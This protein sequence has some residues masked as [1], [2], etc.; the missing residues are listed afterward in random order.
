MKWDV[1]V[2]VQ[3]FELLSLRT[4][5]I[6]RNSSK[7][8]ARE[9]DPESCDVAQRG[10][11]SVRGRYRGG[12]PL[13]ILITRILFGISLITISIA[14]IA[15]DSPLPIFAVA[16]PQDHKPRPDDADVKKEGRRASGINK[17]RF[18]KGGSSL[19][20]SNHEKFKRILVSF[21]KP[22]LSSDELQ[23]IRTR[24]L[25]IRGLKVQP[26]TL[27]IVVFCETFEDQEKA[28]EEFYKH[29]SVKVAMKD[30]LVRSTGAKSLRG[31][32]LEAKK[33]RLL[34]GQ[35]IPSDPR[36]DRQW[37]LHQV[38]GNDADIDAP[39]AWGTYQSEAF[40]VGASPIVVAV[41]DTGVDHKHPDLAGRMWRN[42][43]EI[44]DNGIDDD[45]NGYVDD[46][47]GVDLFNQDGDP[48]DDESH[49]THCAGII[50][51]VENNNEGIAG[52]ASYTSNVQ[53]MAVKFMD[54]EGYGTLTDGIQGIEYAMENGARISSNSWGAESAGFLVW[55]AFTSVLL[56]ARMEGHLFIGASG[57]SGWNLDASSNIPCSLGADNL[58][59]VAS[60]GQFG[61]MSSFSNYGRTQVDLA[62]P[63]SSILST[64]PDGNYLY[65]S[66][67]SMSAPFVAGVAAV[68]WSFRPELSYDNVKRLIMQTVDKSDAF[69]ELSS[70]GR[71]NL[72]SALRQAQLEYP[73]ASPPVSQ[74]GSLAF[75]DT[76]QRVGLVSG[77]V[78][79]TFKSKAFEPA[80]S[81]ALDATK[82]HLYFA[83]ADGTLF[84]P[85]LNNTEPIA[86]AAGTVPTASDAAWT[87]FLPS[88]IVPKEATQI[89]GLSANATGEN[90]QAKATL[91]L[92]DTGRPQHLPKN[93][94]ISADLHTGSGSISS[95]A[96]WDV[97]L[98][99]ADVS[100]YRLFKYDS[101]TNQRVDA[102][103]PVAVVPSRGLFQP[104]CQGSA[105]ASIKVE[106]VFAVD[107]TKQTGYRVKLRPPSGAYEV[108]ERATI[109]VAGPSEIQFTFFDVEYGY[110]TL[111]IPS[112]ETTLT[113]TFT[114]ALI[115]L[116]PGTHSIKWESDETMTKEGWEFVISSDMSYKVPIEIA[117]LQSSVDTLLLI[118]SYNGNEAEDGVRAALVDNAS[119]GST[120]GAPPLSRPT[121]AKM[122][123]VNAAPG[124]MSGKLTIEC[125]APL[126]VEEKETTEES[127]T[128]S[129]TVDGSDVTRFKATLVRMTAP[130]EG[131]T[132]PP[133]E[134]H[135][136]DLGESTKASA[137]IELTDVEAGPDMRIKIVN[138]NEHAFA[139]EG[140][141]MRTLD[142]QGQPILNGKYGGD[143]DS[144][145]GQVAGD[146]SITPPAYGVGL[147]G[148]RAYW[149][150]PTST[151]EDESAATFYQAMQ[152]PIVCPPRPSNRDW[153]AD[154]TNAFAS[155]HCE[156]AFAP[157][158]KGRSCHLVQIL[159]AGDEFTISRS[160]SSNGETEYTAN[161][162]A[163]IY[164]P[165]GGELEV[166]TMDVELIFDALRAKWRPMLGGT[167]Y[168]DLAYYDPGDTLEVDGGTSESYLHWKTDMNEQRSGWVLRYRPKYPVLAIPPD[169]VMP[170]G[171]TGMKIVPVYH[172]YPMIESAAS[173][174]DEKKYAVPSELTA[175]AFEGAADTEYFVPVS[176][177]VRSEAVCLPSKMRCPIPAAW[178]DHNYVTPKTSVDSVSE[179]AMQ[180][181][182]T[183]TNG[184][185]ALFEFTKGKCGSTRIFDNARGLVVD[186]ITLV[187]EAVSDEKPT[188]SAG[189]NVA[190]T[191]D[192]SGVLDFL[193]A[194][195]QEAPVLPPEITCRC[196]SKLTATATL[197]Q[198]IG[199]EAATAPPP[200]QT[201]SVDLVGEGEM[202]TSMRVYQDEVFAQPLAFG[203]WLPQATVEFFIEV[204]TEFTG[205]HITIKSCR[206][207]RNREALMKDDDEED[208]NNSE[209]RVESDV[210]I[211]VPLMWNYC[212]V[213]LFNV[214]KH[215]APDGVTHLDRLSF[216]KFRFTGQNEIYL[217]CE[218][219]ACESR[220]CGTCFG[221]GSGEGDE[222][223]GQKFLRML[224]GRNSRV[225]QNSLKNMNKKFVGR[226][227]QSAA[228]SRTTKTSPLVVRIDENDPSA[229]TS[230]GPLG[231]TSVVATEPWLVNGNAA[232]NPDAPREP[233]IETTWSAPPM[234][235]E[236]VEK[237]ERIQSRMT[238]TG[239]EPQWAQDNVRSLED[240]LKRTLELRDGESVRIKSVGKVVKNSDDSSSTSPARRQ[241]QQ[242][243]T[244][245]PTAST[246]WVTYDDFGK[247]LS[248]LVANS[249]E[250]QKQGPENYRPNWFQNLVA[251]EQQ[252][253][254]QQGGAANGVV[255]A[256][257]AAG[258]APLAA[259]TPAPV[260][261]DIVGPQLPS[262]GQTPGDTAASVS[263]PQPASGS[264]GPASSEGDAAGV[265][266]AQAVPPAESSAAAV[267]GP[268]VAPGAPVEAPAAA[269]GVSKVKETRETIV[270]NTFEDLQKYQAGSVAPATA[271]EAARPTWFQNLVAQEK[272][273]RRE[274]G[275]NGSGVVVQAPAPI[276]SP[277]VEPTTP[278]RVPEA[279]PIPGHDE[280]RR[281]LA[282]HT[283]SHSNKRR[284]GVLRPSAATRL[285][286][287][288]LLVTNV[289]TFMD[290]VRNSRS[291]A[292]LKAQ[293]DVTSHRRQVS[294]KLAA[295]LESV[296][297]DFEVLLLKSA[298]TG[299]GTSS[300]ESAPSTSVENSASSSNQRTMLLETKMSLL[301]SGGPT[302]TNTFV[303][304]LDE[305]L[306]SRGETPVRLETERIQFREPAR[307][308][309]DIS[310][311]LTP[312]EQQG[313]SS[314]S[315]SSGDG[316]A[317]ATGTS[318]AS[319]ASDAQEEK[320]STGLLGFDAATATMLLVV[321]AGAFL[322]LL[323]VFAVCF[324][325]KW[326][327]GSSTDA[328]LL[329]PD[330]TPKVVRE[331]AKTSK[332]VVEEDIENKWNE[333]E[334]NHV[335]AKMTAVASNKGQ[336]EDGD[337][338][339][340]D[341]IGIALQIK[342]STN[343]KKGKK[344]KR[345][346]SA[347]H[348]TAEPPL[349]ITN[350]DDTALVAVSPRPS[351]VSLGERSAAS[352]SSPSSKSKNKKKRDAGSNKAASLNRIYEED[353]EIADVESVNQTSS[354]KARSQSASA[355][356]PKTKLTLTT[357]QGGSI[358]IESDDVEE[359]LKSRE[360]RK[361]L[362]KQM[363]SGAETDDSSSSPLSPSLRQASGSTSLSVFNASAL[364]MHRP[365]SAASTSNILLSTTTS[366]FGS[367]NSSP[368]ISRD[369][370]VAS[371]GS[372]PSRRRATPTHDASSLVWADRRQPLGKLSD[373]SAAVSNPRQAVVAREG[374]ASLNGWGPV[375]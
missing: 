28:I 120:G 258:D 88:S 19:R 141:I 246:N 94:K 373:Y 241:L 374:A 123:D 334:L 274:Q 175:P 31:T 83:R 49:G 364:G 126:L 108:D 239:L 285:L 125:C 33:E 367:R 322:I 70:G 43:G 229:I 197:E 38:A 326:L 276:I 215:A 216:R 47:H 178:A 54:F 263:Q 329:S 7:M 107:A 301:A 223:N 327:R 142:I 113:G 188:E 261:N 186:S 13:S 293:N 136:R 366:S 42:P 183:G 260:A 323:G 249:E 218:V 3:L 67:T 331:F 51:A 137:A 273:M 182:P 283:T 63:G 117:S 294:R 309:P 345:S 165:Y 243:A 262:G 307:I 200:V 348:S 302:L 23:D 338:Q 330:A 298:S 275:G 371:P 346:L 244:S 22:G 286:R 135:V 199:V 189:Q 265:P 180:R 97:G 209:D 226:G 143:L 168:T 312:A 347:K 266:G 133:L 272:T 156:S 333:R 110:D 232:G 105:C 1:V 297:I 284:G 90:Q 370:V 138:G 372:S 118:A 305:E 167:L 60:S 336:D 32:E 357:P 214:K 102:A 92:V 195:P 172:N 354:S 192:Y 77:E 290:H 191:H 149:S 159:Q 375:T 34:Q 147:T 267:G 242:A 130:A 44:P 114:P 190:E 279:V 75:A 314:S 173:S 277:S 295:A 339:L 299:S 337:P 313:S 196:E 264:A 291:A 27:T 46:V 68:L 69:A 321:T 213:P 240:T 193:D 198:P 99:E 157:K 319:P 115:S 96:T 161:E 71:V 131:S 15:W 268:S 219:E 29:Q 256:P 324:V 184:P 194:V 56:A 26:K 318:S 212:P 152:L 270:F 222:T 351:E 235:A 174:D 89:V 36:F 166:V 45:G 206:A 121:V 140:L 62:A 358:T 238:L 169:T 217:Q 101:S 248:S 85:R 50:G 344:S 65:F 9:R 343:M 122:L 84:R 112:L 153:K 210:V 362:R 2:D 100:E 208:P 355:S 231:T 78:R 158:C 204:G 341:G 144:D 288:A 350:I 82:L 306:V 103:T 369:V 80:G 154:P 93:F 271:G 250:T 74:P 353:T 163:K 66:G 61:S 79:V 148:F 359:T 282:Q 87:T 127:A 254:E 233:P 363:G 64:V 24:V 98:T 211:T 10:L 146:V 164:F 48:M 236:E 16:Q 160:A 234:L 111:E 151:A 187:V 145:V 95:T 181:T 41:I 325:R 230:G 37:G 361:I 106:N 11:A 14:F 52:V 221:T 124:I 278:A 224:L 365:S 303:Q 368:V 128:T 296:A 349:S 76:D 227:L 320:P 289:N 155:R 20:N 150:S 202:K 86:I 81:T 310:F 119:G 311:G 252:F 281:R 335:N 225:Y 72:E 304:T 245:G 139:T 170:T 35:L 340:E 30:V 315:S 12:A 58:I 18:D 21:E 251:G 207:S 360:V 6:C 176:D 40:S 317:S 17:P 259:A 269:P 116:P 247:L 57:N 39:E 308:S 104:Q 109:T 59:C 25:G 91:G 162:R 332:Y 5:R 134:T 292:Q 342:S 171:T 352:S 287:D 356:S 55:M 53:I 257:A 228:G 328:H 185:P 237:M 179:C 316:A 129:E 253:R 300:S 4:G 255:V 205:N 203:D 8:E 132:E 73:A 201:E 177:W 220:P 280:N